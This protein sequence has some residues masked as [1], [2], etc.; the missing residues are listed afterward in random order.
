MHQ[1]IASD[2]KYIKFMFIKQFYIITSTISKTKI[3]YFPM[4]VV[5]I[6]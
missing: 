5:Q 6:N 2:G 3:I 1:F 4:K